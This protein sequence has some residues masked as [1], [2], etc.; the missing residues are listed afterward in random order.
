[1]GHIWGFFQIR[2]S[3]FASQMYWIWSEKNPRICPIWGQFDPLWVQIRSLSCLVILTN[4][5]LA[6]AP[7]LT[8]TGQYYIGLLKLIE[9]G[10]NSTTIT[11]TDRWN[12]KSILNTPPISQSWPYFKLIWYPCE[13]WS[14]GKTLLVSGMSGLG[15]RFWPKLVH[16]IV[17]MYKVQG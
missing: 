10:W 7:D 5:S 6:C 11:T 8:K 2:F 12:T 13:T 14:P 15:V 3:T 17:T 1:M 4:H 16:M 9:V